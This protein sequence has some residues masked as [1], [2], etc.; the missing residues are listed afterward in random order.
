M[1][2]EWSLLRDLTSFFFYCVM[3]ILR[4]NR[5]LCSSRLFFSYCLLEC[6]ECLIWHLTKP[7][8][9]QLETWV[10]SWQPEGID[11][12][13]AWGWQRVYK[14]KVV[15]IRIAKMRHE[16]LWMFICCS[17]HD[18]DEDE[19]CYYWFDESE[20]ASSPSSS[21]FPGTMNWVGRRGIFV[22]N[23]PRSMRCLRRWRG[24]KKGRS[25]SRSIQGCHS[26]CHSRNTCRPWVQPE[27]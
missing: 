20:S 21:M 2:W 24:W 25:W 11:R 27:G 23:I 1:K 16:C 15:Q 6:L 12:D 19:R 18:R 4:Q 3:Y 7:K 10:E 22:L 5:W 26:N 14:E 8:V 13:A 17:L 9:Q